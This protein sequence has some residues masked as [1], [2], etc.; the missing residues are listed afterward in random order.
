MADFVTGEDDRQILWPRGL[1]DLVEPRQFDTEHDAVKEQQSGERLVLGRRGDL[2]T[3]RERGQER[4][5]FS[6]RHLGRVTPVVEEDVPLDP[7][8]VSL[9]GAA[10]GVSRPDRVPDPVEQSR[11]W[12]AGELSF[13]YPVCGRGDGF[14]R[15]R[16]RTR[17][18]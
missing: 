4:G 7:V 10:T 1:D 5:D 13:A 3:N 14:Y 11:F 18:A 6:R 2:V 15:H 17:A 8:D 12:R 16:I 9:L